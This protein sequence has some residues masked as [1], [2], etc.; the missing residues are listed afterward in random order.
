MLDIEYPS[1]RAFVRDCRACQR[2]LGINYDG[3]GLS[4]AD[5]N[6]RTLLTTGEYTLLPDGRVVAS[7]YL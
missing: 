4:A 7:E 2:Y 6:P 1:L 3:S 5:Y